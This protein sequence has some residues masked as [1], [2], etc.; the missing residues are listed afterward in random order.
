MNINSL[1]QYIKSKQK[2]LTDKYNCPD[3]NILYMS[4][5]DILNTTIEE[6]NQLILALEEYQYAVNSKFPDKKTS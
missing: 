4:F 3:F 1:I 6:R 5:E 2:R